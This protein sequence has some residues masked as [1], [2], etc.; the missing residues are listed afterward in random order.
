MWYAIPMILWNQPAPA[1]DH[2]FKNVFEQSN[3]NRLCETAQTD[4]ETLIFKLHSIESICYVHPCS[5]GR[6]YYNGVCLSVREHI[7]TTIDPL[8]SI[9]RHKIG[10]TQGSV[11]LKDAPNLEV[12]PDFMVQFPVV[13]F[14]HIYQ[15]PLIQFIPFFTNNKWRDILLKRNA[16]QWM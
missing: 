8:H 6:R 1:S 15:Q 10:S 5:G 11:I 16:N 12:D 2:Q 9:F 13:D 7:S 14:S 4:S 3:E